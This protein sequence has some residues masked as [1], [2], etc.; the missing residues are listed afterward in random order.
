[1]IAVEFTGKLVAACE[2]LKPALALVALVNDMDRAVRARRLPVGTGEPPAGI[3]HPQARLRAR[4]RPDGVL[5]AVGDA[6]AFIALG[7]FDDRVERS[8]RIVGFE[9]LRVGAA[10]A[11]RADVADEQDVGGIGAPGQNVIFDVP[12]VERF[13]DGG[14]NL[15]RIEPRR[16]NRATRRLNRI[17]AGGGNWVARS[18]VVHRCLVVLPCPE[19]LTRTARQ[20]SP[21]AE[22]EI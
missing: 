17:V 16:R 11:E 12:A 21:L 2:V 8:L 19:R 18:L 7:G 14:E 15:A 6:L 9:Q 1:V 3:L 20:N 13:A 10:A 5:D 4:I 22:R